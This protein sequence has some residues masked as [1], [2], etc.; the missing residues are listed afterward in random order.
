ML[1][2]LGVSL[3]VAALDVAVPTA[4]DA[5]LG[6]LSALALPVA[7]V[8]VGGSLR[9][10]GYGAAAG[11]TGRVVALKVLVMPA[12]A[13]VVFTP[14]AVDPLVRDTAVVM[15]GAPTAVSTSVYATELGGDAT[16]AS[17]NVFATTLA[18]LA[19]LFASLAVLA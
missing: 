15:F 3:A 7:L 5:S 11:R 1:L 2:T 4:V 14:L 13:W 19:T 9:T 17:L 6:R 18:A 8:A 10:T 12:V 16:F